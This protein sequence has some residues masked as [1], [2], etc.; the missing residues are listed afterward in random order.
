LFAKATATTLY[1]FFTRS[2]AAQRVGAVLALRKAA[3][4]RKIA[5]DVFVAS[6]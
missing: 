2:S 4:D 1:G 3:A 6:G 5:E